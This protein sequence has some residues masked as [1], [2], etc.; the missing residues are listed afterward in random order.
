MKTHTSAN[1]A[2]AVLA[3]A[4]LGG[5]DGLAPFRRFVTGAGGHSRGSRV[6]ESAHAT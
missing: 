6:S 1:F 3:G 5:S 2:E 4:D